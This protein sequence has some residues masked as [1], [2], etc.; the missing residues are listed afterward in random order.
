M[1]AKAKIN[2]KKPCSNLRMGKCVYGF[3]D[4]YWR[5]RNWYWY[6]GMCQLWHSKYFWNVRCIPNW[7]IWTRQRGRVFSI[8]I[9]EPEDTNL[10]KDIEKVDQ[11]SESRWFV[12]DLFP[13]ESRE[14]K[15]KEEF[16]KE[17]MKRSRKFLLLEIKHDHGVSRQRL[18][19]TIERVGTKRFES[20]K[21]LIEMKERSPS[22]APFFFEI[23]KCGSA[24]LFFLKEIIF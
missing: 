5:Q 4:R 24:R 19:E 1:E 20:L 7:Q 14:R 6:L 23:C 22:E 13:N 17:K 2:D 9:S 3:C 18:V 15:G 21:F 11:S 10:S 12:T 8:S 16:E